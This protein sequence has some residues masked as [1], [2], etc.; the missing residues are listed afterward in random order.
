MKLKSFLFFFA[1]CFM[2][3]IGQAQ[4]KKALASADSTKNPIF[5][6]DGKILEAQD[7]KDMLKK[8]DPQTI[9]KIEVYKDVEAQAL[10]GQKGING[11]VVITTKKEKNKEK[12]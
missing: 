2:T 6:L 10:Y 8:I 9:Q 7:S 4:I 3:L 12:N 5:V 11:V 1:F